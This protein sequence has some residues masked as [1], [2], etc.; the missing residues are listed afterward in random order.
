MSRIESWQEVI[1]KVT[2]K[3]ST[4]KV[5]TLSVGGR[6]TLLK[7]V[8]GAIPT[9][10]MSIYKA[11]K[12]VINFLESVRNKFFLGAD[13]DERKMTWISWKKVLANRRDGGLGVN[14]IFALNHALLFK[15]IWRFLSHPHA[16]WVRVVKAIHGEKG[17]INCNIPK[18]LSIDK[19][20][21]RVNLDARGIDVPSV[22]CP[23]VGYSYSSY[24]ML[25]TMV[26]LVLGS[27]VKNG[28]KTVFGGNVLVGMV[29]CVVS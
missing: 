22:L 26:R 4:W 28:A 29:A 15:W 6:L 13:I 23:V 27:S 3:L 14:S 17:L 11:P 12:A 10:Y 18:S 8:L 1:S 25:S 7:S 5:K 20:P 24:E 2:N 16:L 21:T 19:L 9:Y